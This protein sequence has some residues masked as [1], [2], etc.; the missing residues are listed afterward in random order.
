MKRLISIMVGLSMTAGLLSLAGCSDKDSSDATISESGMPVSGVVSIASE[1]APSS[2]EEIVAPV[3]L[4]HTYTTM[5]E[6]VNAVTF[7]PFSFDYPDGW[8]IIQQDVTQ[9]GETIVLENGNSAKI[10]YMHVSSS[11]AT[12]GTS[13][14]NMMRIDVSKVADSSFVP[15]YVQ[16]ADHSDL[17]PFIVAQLKLTGTLDMV[18]ESDFV[19]VDGGVAYAVLPESYIGSTAIRGPFEY[20][21]MFPYSSNISFTSSF[22]N[23]GF[24]EQEQREIISIL[25]SFRTADIPPS[26]N[27]E[28]SQGDDGLVYD[29]NG[30]IVGG[31]EAGDD[32]GGLA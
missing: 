28:T 2:S 16:A 8:E 5:F 11:V 10:T 20:E 29:E 12:Y 19:E 6:E 13:Q 21:F 30:N 9:D 15:G 7:Q 27:G 4:N 22:S 32:G 25:A 18:D 14:A 23:D 31:V 17:G 26:P 1:T 24:S 3:V